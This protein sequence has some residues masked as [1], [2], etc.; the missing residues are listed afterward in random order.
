MRSR[1]LAVL[2]MVV[3]AGTLL[4]ACGSDDS[5]TIKIGVADASES[6]WKVFTEKASAQGIDVKLVNFTDYNQPNPALAEGEL[7]LNEFQHLLYL[8]TYN[9]KNNQD[10]VPIGATAVYPLP[11]YSKRYQAVADIPQGAQVVI[12]NDPTNQARGLLVL[13]QA[14][15]ITL[16]T[17]GS[18]F[19]TL[20][21][22]DQSRS[23]VK[24]VAVDAGQTAANL[25][26]V[27]A[28]IVNNNYATSAG[29]TAKEVIASD[30]PNAPAARPYINAFVARAAD[31]D[32]Q[33][34]AKLVQI[35]HDPEV[36]A[37]VKESLGDAGVIKD[38]PASELQQTLTE[39]E[40]SVKADG[41]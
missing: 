4:T 32:N 24:V 29:L 21:D 26:S 10:L 27:A 33:T 37:A 12:P 31:K 5:S 8:A 15:L 9:V 22:I 17:P 11:L 13:E 18:P 16:T 25:D 19:S 1:I 7:D 20:A 41:S 35:Y 30:D 28:A 3:F 23:K 6:Y 40:A 34:Y 38:N 39:L 36:I 14:G 2:L